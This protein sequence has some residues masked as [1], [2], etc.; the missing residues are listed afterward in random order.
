MAVGYSNLRKAL[1]KIAELS[2]KE[3]RKREGY[4][5]NGAYYFLEPELLD[6]K[7]PREAEQIEI[8]LPDVTNRLFLLPPTPDSVTCLLA[9]KWDFSTP[10]EGVQAPEEQEISYAPRVF[11]LFLM[12]SD[13]GGSV[14][15]TVVRFDEREEDTAWR[16]PHAQLCDTVVPYERH[17]PPRDPACWVSATLPR[18]PLAAPEGPEPILV[19]LLASLYGVDSAVLNEVVRELHDEGSRNVAEALGWRE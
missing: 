13:A 18:I 1:L 15:P 17:F 4:P 2:E 10:G 6:K 14:T 7:L 8:P 12:S 9:V 11:R 19:C 16:F 3:W 5:L